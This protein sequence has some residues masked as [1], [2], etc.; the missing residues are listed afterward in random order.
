MAVGAFRARL[1]GQRLRAIAGLSCSQPRVFLE[2][3]LCLHSLS[4]VMKPP[5]HSQSP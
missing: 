1:K 5:S 3:P 4:L 2:L